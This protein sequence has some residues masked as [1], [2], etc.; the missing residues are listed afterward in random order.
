MTTT[1]DEQPAA[2]PDLDFERIPGAD[3]AT[4]YRLLIAEIDRQARA[5]V[6][7]AAGL[8]DFAD[9]LYS[10]EL[11]LPDVAEAGED[12][13]APGAL[14]IPA[15]QNAVDLLRL[16]LREAAHQA[17][18]VGGHYQRVARR[19][20]DDLAAEL[21]TPYCAFRILALDEI[22]ELGYLKP[23]DRWVDGNGEPF[24]PGSPLHVTAHRLQQAGLLPGFDDDIEAGDLEHAT[25]PEPEQR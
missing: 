22:G 21:R 18:A 11:F 5:A 8:G 12:A 15:G 10:T 19:L 25:A 23:S 7:A 1:T 20:R 4:G 14:G 6:E 9:T 3:E 2:A 17:Y 16:R 13:L 24:K